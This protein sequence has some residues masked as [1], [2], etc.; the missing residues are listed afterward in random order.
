M[1]DFKKN[2]TKDKRIAGIADAQCATDLMGDLSVCSK[3]HADPGHFISCLVEEK[4]KVKNEACLA[5]INKVAVVVFSDYRLV[6]F[7]TE[8]LIIVAC[9]LAEYQF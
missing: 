8:V 5:F 3:Y 9:L 1:W 2:V 7:F 4:Q 6:S